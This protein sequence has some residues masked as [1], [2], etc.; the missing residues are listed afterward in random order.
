MKVRNFGRNNYSLTLK[1]VKD[2]DGTHDHVTLFI[3]G[4]NAGYFHLGVYENP[5]QIWL[6]KFNPT[7]FGEQFEIRKG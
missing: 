4:E 3:N 6:F 5:K 7:K 2:P 1:V